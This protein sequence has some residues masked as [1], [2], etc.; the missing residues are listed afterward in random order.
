LRLDH[1]V[2][3]SGEDPAIIRLDPRLTVVS[4]MGRTERAELFE[5]LAATLAGEPSEARELTYVDGTGRTVQMVRGATGIRFLADDGTGIISPMVALGL[6][7]AGLRKLMLVEP[8]D[9][10]V[11]HVDSLDDDS[12][13]L[14]EARATLL[15][16]E[17]ELARAL[18]LQGRVDALRADIASADEQLR[19][20]EEGGAKRRYARI[21]AEL[22]RVQVEASSLRGGAAAVGADRRLIG[23]R[24]EVQRLRERWQGAS[25]DLDR[26]RQRFAGRERLDARTLEEALATPDRVPPELDA[27]A[28]AY[29]AAV[30]RRATVNDKLTALATEHLAEPSHPAIVRLAHADQDEVWANAQRAIDAVRHL[31][32]QSLALGGLQAE[33]VAPAAVAELELAHDEVDRAERVVSHRFWPGAAGMATGVLVTGG[34]LML[35]PLLAA[36]GT[37]IVLAVGVW[38]VGV[39]RRELSAARSKEHWALEQAGVPSYIGFQ[40][41]RLEVTINPSATEPLELAALE[42]RRAMTQWR[43]LAG[44]LAPSE[45]LA[46]EDETRAYASSMAGLRGTANQIAQA[47]EELVNGAEPALGDAR[48]RLLRACAPFGITDPNLAVELVRHQVHTNSHARLQ[49]DLQQAEDAFADA[50]GELSAVLESLGMAGDDLDAMIA[51]F[52]RAVATAEG[53]ERARAVARPA[54]EVEAD[55]GRLEALV[56]SEHRPEWAQTVSPADGQEPDVESLRNQRSR[57]LAEFTDLR[58]T[59]PDI[60][61]LKDRRDAV[62]RRVT[63]LSASGAVAEVESIDAHDLEHLLLARLAAARRVGPGSET[64]PLVLNEPFPSM[65]SDRKWGLLD[66]VERLAASVQLIFLTDDVDTIVWARRRAA[67][68]ALRLLEPVAETV[69]R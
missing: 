33:G 9:V 13:E 31:E 50:E 11:I 46:M 14:Q 66:T 68:G 24:P 67:A 63:V 8:I 69:G 12:G 6:D 16:L 10:G 22:D 25:E 18:V 53:R 56:R 30:T 1:L 20:A 60:D 65:P 26:E 2:I 34:G 64:V 57:A 52:D 55:L 49:H 15:T 48:D 43:K 58:R 19:Q 41:R 42:Y 23:H 59:L 5:L 21:L 7:P 36:L 32:G 3:G 27:L 45:A 39:P 47:R 28:A 44:D 17:E 4:G 40:Y 35:S 37:V 29:E 62:R 38:A 51:E 54:E 61:R